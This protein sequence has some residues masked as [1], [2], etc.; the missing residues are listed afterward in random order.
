M[1][2]NYNLMD[3]KCYGNDYVFYM[4]HTSDQVTINNTHLRVHSVTGRESS[5]T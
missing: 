3:K 4:T 1:T 2:H 5:S